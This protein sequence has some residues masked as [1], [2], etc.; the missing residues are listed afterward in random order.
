MKLKT[1][2]RAAKPSEPLPAETVK[3]V[4]GR[5]SYC[6]M[7]KVGPTHSGTV[8]G[9]DLRTA[10]AKTLHAKYW[11]ALP[12]RKVDCDACVEALGG[13]KASNGKAT[14]AP[15]KRV[16]ADAKRREVKTNGSTEG[17]AMGETTPET[18]VAQRR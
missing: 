15:T 9:D 8:K 1:K 12:N 11:R 18:A 13:K 7:H 2:T 16:K 14:P 6:H 17:I 4:T 5:T 10:C 3:T